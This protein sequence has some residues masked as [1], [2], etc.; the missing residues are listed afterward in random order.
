MPKVILFEGLTINSIK[1]ALLKANFDLKCTSC[2]KELLSLVIE[3]QPDIAIVNGDLNT[4]LELVKQIRN[5]QYEFSLSLIALLDTWDIDKQRSLLK[6]G[7]NAVLCAP[8]NTHL[9]IDQANSLI[10]N[11]K[12]VMK[13]AEMKLIQRLGGVQ[14]VGNLFLN[15]A[16]R[17]VK[18]NYSNPEFNVSALSKQMK[19]SRSCLYMK[20]RSATAMSAS[21]FIRKIRLTEA[22]IL[23]TNSNLNISEVTYQVG[24]ND[25]KYLS[26]QF[27]IL[28]G[29][30]PSEFKKSMMVR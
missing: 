3:E 24:L 9:L 7:Y 14:E 16:I 19:I 18:D 26:K 2:P 11:Q 4:M 29:L 15:R 6:A 21:Q 1:K 5:D 22:A 27:K 25:P 23:L 8:I 13:T 10:R 30:T 12:L 20:I 28:Y 17:L